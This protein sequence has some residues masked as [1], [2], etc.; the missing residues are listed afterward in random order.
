MYTRYTAPVALPDTFGH[1]VE[2]LRQGRGADAAGLLVRALKQP[3][4]SRDET[5]QLRCALAE[6]WFQ[7]DDIRQAGEALG[8]PPDERERLHPARLSE[9]WRLHG[10]LAIARGE[11]SRAIALLGRALKSAERAHDSRA[12]GL[13]HYDLDPATGRSATPPSS[14]TISRR[15]RLR[16]TRPATSAAWRSCTR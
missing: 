11:P 7:Q 1:A 8:P 15:R 16:S 3:G 12:I 5:L 13:T 2:A 6:A 9:L 10:R 14:A 4:L